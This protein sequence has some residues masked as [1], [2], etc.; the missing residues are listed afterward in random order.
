MLETAEIPDNDSQKVGAKSSFWIELAV[1]FLMMDRNSSG[2]G[3]FLDEENIS[4]DTLISGILKRNSVVEA[5][6]ADVMALEQGH[7]CSKDISFS[8]QLA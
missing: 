5:A 3:D 2:G 1:I 8:D 4:G 6:M 7:S